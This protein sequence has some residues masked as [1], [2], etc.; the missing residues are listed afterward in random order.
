MQQQA[1]DTVAKKAKPASA[2]AI[3]ELYETFQVP[4]GGM[5][6]GMLAAVDWTL[7]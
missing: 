5:G 4:W 7:D 2:E 6:V 3:P 1:L